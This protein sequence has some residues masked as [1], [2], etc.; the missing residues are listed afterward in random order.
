LG[1]LFRAK[2]RE[3][4]GINLTVRWDDYAPIEIEGDDG[5]PLSVWPRKPQERTV[6]EANG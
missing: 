3:A 6:P 4:Q 2:E 1:R 5:T